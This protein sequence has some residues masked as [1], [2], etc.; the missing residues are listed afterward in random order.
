MSSLFCYMI[1][2]TK[3][4]TNF[5]GK[6]KNRS[7]LWGRHKSDKSP[8]ASSMAYWGELMHRDFPRFPGHLAYSYAI[9]ARLRLSS[10]TRR[11]CCF[12]DITYLLKH[13]AGNL[14]L[15]RRWRKCQEIIL[16]DNYRES[17]RS[18]IFSISFGTHF[19]FF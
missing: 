18:S 7:F 9:W 6:I 12:L 17:R 16:W 1:N 14:S 13:Q 5:F 3:Q 19:V 10:L 8:V 11:H 2:C 4:T 15:R